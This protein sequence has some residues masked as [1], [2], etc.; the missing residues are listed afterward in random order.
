MVTQVRDDVKLSAIGGEARTLQEWLTTFQLF[1]VVID[2][3]T[4]ESAWL[5]RTAGRILSHFSEA[6]CRVAWVV[7]ADEDDAAKF[8]GPWADQILTFTDPDREFVKALELERL[9][10]LVYLRQDLAIMGKTEGWNSAE[11]EQVCALAAQ[12][13]SW[14]SPRFPSPGDPGSFEGSPA[15][16]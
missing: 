13:N 6:D 9:P 12:V 7:T 16:G 10:A 4:H 1:T 5:L 2:P 11:W 14:S 15:L 8:L 3:Y